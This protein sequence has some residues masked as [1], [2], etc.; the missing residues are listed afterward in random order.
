LKYATMNFVFCWEANISL[1]VLSCGL[2]ET[3][4]VDYTDFEDLKILIEKSFCKIRRGG[5]LRPPPF[6]GAV[7]VAH[8]SL[9]LPPPPSPLPFPP[10]RKGKRGRGRRGRGDGGGGGEAWKRVVSTGLN[11]FQQV[12]TCFNRS[13][14]VS[15]GSNGSQQVPTGSDGF[16]WVPPNMD[17][18]RMFLDVSG[19]FR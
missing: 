17:T 8:S 10:K 14:R 2:R 11:V 9:P 5:G 15:T 3:S 13:E 12:W 19:L 6:R 18:T 1:V 4:S 7:V 16:Q